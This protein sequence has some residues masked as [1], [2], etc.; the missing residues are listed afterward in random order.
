MRVAQVSRQHQRDDLPTPVGEQPGAAGPAIEDDVDGVGILALI[1]EIGMRGDL[2]ALA[3]GFLQPEL[4]DIR[5]TSEALQFKREQI[6]SHTLT[7]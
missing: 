4:I 6:G 7:I 2:P 1:D 3:E 5:K